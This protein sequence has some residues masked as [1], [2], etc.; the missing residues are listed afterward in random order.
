MVDSC[1]IVGRSSATL[2]QQNV[3]EIKDKVE[4]VLIQVKHFSVK[5]R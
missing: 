2:T 5:V 4:K 3:K 1:V